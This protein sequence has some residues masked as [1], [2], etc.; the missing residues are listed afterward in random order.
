MKQMTIYVI[1][2]GLM[3][4][5]LMGCVAIVKGWKNI[6]SGEPALRCHCLNW[7]SSG[8]K[9]RLWR[10]HLYWLLVGV[11]LLRLCPPRLL[12]PLTPLALLVSDA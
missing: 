10:E 5:T 11:P 2:T 12:P 3:V 7:Y 9:S 4:R 6:L 1:D 8:L